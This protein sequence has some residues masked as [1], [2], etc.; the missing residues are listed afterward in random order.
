MAHVQT[1]PG[2]DFSPEEGVKRIKAERTRNEITALSIGMAVIILFGTVV[3]LSFHGVPAPS[4][5]ANA[6]PYMTQ[7]YH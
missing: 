1:H 3:Y 5:P 4:T 2:Y 6:N 7:P